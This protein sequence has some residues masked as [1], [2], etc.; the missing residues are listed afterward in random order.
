M[1]KNRFRVRVVPEADLEGIRA[2]FHLYNNE[3]E[4][5]RVLAEIQSCLS[6]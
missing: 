3:N 5:E 4:T 2:S 1:I 6:G